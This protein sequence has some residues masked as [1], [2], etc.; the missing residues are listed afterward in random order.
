M[1]GMNTPQLSF[2]FS[3]V[4]YL[5]LCLNPCPN[6]PLLLKFYPSIHHVLSCGFDSSGFGLGYDLPF[7]WLGCP[8]GKDVNA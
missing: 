7:Q 8:R 1:I 4:F 3:H 2:L 6:E 5:V